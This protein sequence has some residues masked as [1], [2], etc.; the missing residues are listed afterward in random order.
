MISKW[1]S[2]YFSA[3]N[4]KAKPFLGKQKSIQ[5]MS[6]TK[7]T[8]LGMF[9]LLICRESRKDLQDSTSSKGNCIFIILINSIIFF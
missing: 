4:R 5:E 2:D 3:N 8:A 1:K 9:E 6:N 7:Q